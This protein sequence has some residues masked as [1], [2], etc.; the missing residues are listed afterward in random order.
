[1]EDNKNYQIKSIVLSESQFSRE[2]L[3]DFNFEGYNHDV[4]V[5]LDSKF[6]V[7][8]NELQ[9]GLTLKYELG[10]E[11]KKDVKAVISFIGIFHCPSEPSVPIDTFEKLNGPAII[12]P[13]VREHLAG[14]TMKAMLPPILLPSFNFSTMKSINSS[15]SGSVE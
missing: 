14:L 13:F 2:A 11:V 4:Q 5:N 8:T 3:I 1:M 6:N 10:N 7:K 15:E 12:F 9:I